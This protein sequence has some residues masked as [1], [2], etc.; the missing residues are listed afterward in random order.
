MREQPYRL[1]QMNRYVRTAVLI[2]REEAIYVRHLQVQPEHILL[3][4]IQVPDSITEA[5]LS[6][7]DVTAQITRKVMS[8]NYDRFEKVSD[9]SLA[10]KEL[11]SWNINLDDV[12]KVIRDVT[13]KAGKVAPMNYSP[14]TSSASF[15]LM[16]LATEMVLKQKAKHFF[17]EHVLLALFSL[18]DSYTKV[19]LE[20]VG[21][22]Q[23]RVQQTLEIMRDDTQEF[24]DTKNTGFSEIR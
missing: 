6:S 21:L 4:L 9:V 7:M 15:D 1:P 14:E 18:P 20:S 3:G 11:A 22:E 24:K 8:E 23:A 16:S 17:T 19:F 12:M 2:A 10:R 5:V 13:P